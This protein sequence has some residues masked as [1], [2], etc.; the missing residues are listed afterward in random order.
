MGAELVTRYSFHYK[1]YNLKM[2]RYSWTSCTSWGTPSQRLTC[3]LRLSFL[4]DLFLEFC[5][6]ILCQKPSQKAAIVGLLVIQSVRHA[7]LYLR[8]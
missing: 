7:D 4:Q 1:K 5:E 8:V 2:L 3:L 6:C